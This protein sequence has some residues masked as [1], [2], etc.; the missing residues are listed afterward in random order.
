MP[1]HDPTLLAAS[2]AHARAARTGDPK[3]I[4]AARTALNEAKIRS[5]VERTLK[6]APPNLSPATKATLA[7]LLVTTDAAR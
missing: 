1:K 4:K 3:K 2:A 5:W 6:E 7:R